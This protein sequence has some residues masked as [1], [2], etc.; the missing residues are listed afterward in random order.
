M[1]KVFKNKNCMLSECNREYTPTSTTQRYCSKECKEKQRIK[2]GGKNNTIIICKI[3][4]KE[5]IPQWN[6]QQ[7]CSIECLKK[8][9]SINNKVYKDKK[10]TWDIPKPCKHC[11]NIFTPPHHESEFCSKECKRMYLK[12]YHDNYYEENKSTLSIKQREYN[13]RTKEQRK[14]ASIKRMQTEEGKNTRRNSQQGYKARKRGA[15]VVEKIDYDLIWQR[16]NGKCQHCKKKIDLNIPRNEP[17]GLQYDHIVP[18][19]KGGEHSVKNLQLSHAVCN[20][21]KNNNIS[22]GVQMHLF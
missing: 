18:L 13:E 9:K 3:C 2:N 14:E 17:M 12:I 16:D 5:F 21:R 10:K 11:F 8:S 7:C 19:S 4:N 6:S 15:T 1:D 22:K 20:Q